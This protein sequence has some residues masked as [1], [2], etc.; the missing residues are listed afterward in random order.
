[1]TRVALFLLP[2]LS[3]PVL[4][5]QSVLAYGTFSAAHLSNA[6]LD[7]TYTS[8]G[9]TTQRSGRWA[10]E[11]GLGLTFPIGQAGP[12]RFGLDL[13]GS[14]RGSNGVAS[15]L[16]GLKLAFHPPALRLKPYTQL[17]FGYFSL[18]SPQTTTFAYNV[19][20]A[21]SGSFITTAYE[22]D[23]GFELIGGV[24]YPLAHRLDLR[25]IELGIGHATEFDL[26]GGTGNGHTVF[27]LNSG[28]V[29]RF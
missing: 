8:S 1:M 27:T 11:F 23:T 12:V 15:A 7:T 5:A 18:A 26:L 6:A 19:P 17:S 10:E 14:P 28:L 13:R 16:I 20:N 24:D 22:N 4:H 2:L 21:P 3:V 9:D 29:L 25:V